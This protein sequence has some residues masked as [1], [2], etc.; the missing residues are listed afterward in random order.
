MYLLMAKRRKPKSKDQVRTFYK[1]GGFSTF[2]KVCRV[3]FNKL[4]K[5]KEYDSLSVKEKRYMFSNKLVVTKPVA[6]KSQPIPSKELQKLGDCIQKKIRVCSFK[7]SNKWFSPYELQLF[8]LLGNLINSHMV[9]ANR[10]KALKD[11]FGTRALDTETFMPP[12]FLAIIKAAMSLSS[13]D[14]KYFS[15]DIR[16]AAVVKDNPEIEMSVMLYVNPARKKHIK[17]NNIYRPAFLIG[18]PNL[19][20][21]MDW[22]KIESGFL[23]GAYGGKKEELMVYMQSHANKRLKERLD[24]LHPSSIYHTIWQNITEMDKFI[25]YKDYLL[26]PYQLH[27]CKVGYLVADVIDDILV[28]K[29]FL[30]ITHSAT[31][32]GDKLKEISG[33]A[34]QDISYWKID[35]LSTFVNIDTE[36]YPRLTAMFEEAGLGDLFQLKN[37]AFDLDSLQDANM[38]ALRDYIAQGKQEVSMGFV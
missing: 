29:T 33:L 18:L 20:L 5:L 1:R 25:F 21:R 15:I 34:W 38:D 23:K 13:I 12:F 7:S 14:T 16:M 30:F 36:K 10:K 11:M 8:W 37:K 31:P 28:F 22:L 3:F 17:I 32:E 35:R 4:N 27:N 26:F 19:N 9:S 24:L 6:A 2:D